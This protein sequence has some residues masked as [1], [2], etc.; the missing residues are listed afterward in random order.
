MDGRMA[1]IIRF[2]PPQR[3]A[4]PPAT[5]ETLPPCQIV[6]FTGVR[7]ERTVMLPVGDAPGLRPDDG[8]GQGTS[9][10]RKTS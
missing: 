10:P 2:N 6:I 3:A 9:R 4:A 5:G 8:A 7:I 1:T